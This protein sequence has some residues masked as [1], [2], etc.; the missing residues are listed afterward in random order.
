MTRVLF[1]CSQNKLRSPS[2]ERLFCGCAG[3][4]VASAGLNHDAEVPLTAELVEWADTIFV[5]EKAHGN[6]LRAKFRAQL[7]HQNIICLNIPDQ[8][9][10]M[11]PALLRI[12]QDRVPRH[13][14]A[15]RKAP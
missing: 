10:Y 2:A 14:P 1:V 9:E 11:D 6:K 4:E 12:L 13:V 3:I 15:L 5:M 7:K 8:F